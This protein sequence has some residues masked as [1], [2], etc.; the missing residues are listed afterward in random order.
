[1]L[2]LP[3][4]AFGGIL[5]AVLVVVALAGSIWFRRI[6]AQIAQL[7]DRVKRSTRMKP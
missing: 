2:P 3:P 6:S 1:M 5:S 7:I 4:M